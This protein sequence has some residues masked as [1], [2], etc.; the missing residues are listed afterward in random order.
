MNPAKI[1]FA[2]SDTLRSD[3]GKK[4]AKLINDIIMSEYESSK[5]TRANYYKEAETKSIPGNKHVIQ[6]Q[7]I[8]DNNYFSFTEATFE[9]PE[10]KY[11][12]S[13]MDYEAVFT[14]EMKYRLLSEVCTC[15][16]ILPDKTF[17]CY[18]GK[19]K[20]V[21]FIPSHAFKIFVVEQ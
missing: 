4:T 3:Q 18:K 6:N 11:D 13:M 9:P 14:W 15:I 7:L 1:R 16:E 8:V 19:D 21:E 10:L 17:V 5:K 2:Y 20:E 12:R